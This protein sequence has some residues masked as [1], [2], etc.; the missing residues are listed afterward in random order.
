VARPSALTPALTESIVT[1]VELG[2]RPPIAPR[3]LRR[4]RER[5]RREIAALSAEAKL[6]LA[7][8]VAE[9]RQRALS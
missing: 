2:L 7:L 4:W 1:A 6:A 9:E 8:D 3:T 5:G